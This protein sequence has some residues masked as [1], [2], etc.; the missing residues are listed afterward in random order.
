M[1]SAICH[2]YCKKFG[3]YREAEALGNRRDELF[4][5]A[6]SLADQQETLDHQSFPARRAGMART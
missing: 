1:T 2:G 4:N 5:R 6:M 3:S